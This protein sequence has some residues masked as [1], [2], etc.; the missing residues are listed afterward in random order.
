ML[1][2]W[3]ELKKRRRQNVVVLVR[4]LVLGSRFFVLT[5]VSLPAVPF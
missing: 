1:K 5:L 4:V 2:I 3:T